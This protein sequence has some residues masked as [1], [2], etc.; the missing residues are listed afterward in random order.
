MVGISNLIDGAIELARTLAPLVPVLGP[1]A[2]IAEKLDSIF[3][4]LK[5]HA[6]PSQQAE[7]QTERAVLREKVIA[8]A[9]AESAALRGE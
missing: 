9:K 5:D 8:K 7:M 6:D 2:D 1:A 3:D 4:D